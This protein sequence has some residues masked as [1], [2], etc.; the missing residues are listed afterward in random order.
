MKKTINSK[1]IGSMVVYTLLS[2]FLCMVG[3]G[4]TSAAELNPVVKID[5]TSYTSSGTE[6]TA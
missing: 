1:L 2:L 5:N 4:N 6:V 3:V